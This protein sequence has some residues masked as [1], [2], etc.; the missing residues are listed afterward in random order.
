VDVKSEVQARQRVAA[1]GTF[2]KQKGHSFS[3]G[4]G[5]AISSL[6]L[7]LAIA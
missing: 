2:S 5:G 1:R 6:R 4:A 7:N 3:V